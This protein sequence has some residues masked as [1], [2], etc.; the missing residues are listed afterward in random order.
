MSKGFLFLIPMVLAVIVAF[1]L[2]G[3]TMYAPHWTVATLLAS[4]TVV[5]FYI[6]QSRKNNDKN[7]PGD[8]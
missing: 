6:R 3:I 8:T 4:G 1:A 2:N 7:E 5:F